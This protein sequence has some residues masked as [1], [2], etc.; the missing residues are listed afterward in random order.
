MGCSPSSSQESV[1]LQDASTGEG[2]GQ[3][4]DTVAEGASDRNEANGSESSI[5]DT[6]SSDGV[7]PEATREE[8]PES[9]PDNTT[10]KTPNILL[11]I[12]DDYGID[13]AGAYHDDNNDGKPDDGRT[14]ATTPRIDGI[15]KNGV[16]FL[17][18]WSTPLCSS[19]RASMLTGRYGFRTGIG[20]AIE[21]NAGIG[22][23]EP[24][25]PKI[26]DAHP[27]LGYVHANIGKWHLGKTADLNREQAPNTMGWSHYTGNLEG[28]LPQYDAWDK[29]TDGQSSSSTT[30]ATTENVDDTIRWLEKQQKGKPWLVWLAFN[31][32]HSPFHLPPKNLH[33]QQNLSGTQ[34][35]INQNTPPYYRAMIEAMDSEMG[36]LL[37]WLQT[38]NQLDNTVIVFLGDNGTPAKVVEAPY[39]RRRAK[40]TLYQGG[41]HVPF[42]VSGPVVKQ[43]GRTTDALIHTVDVF[44][45]ILEIAGVIPNSGWTQG[46]TYDSKSFLSVLRDP[47]AASPRSWVFSEFFDST[48]KNHTV[49]NQRYK[50]LRLDNQGT[51]VESMYDLQQDPRE[52]TDLLANGVNGLTSEQKAQYDGLVKELDALLKSP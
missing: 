26:L 35:D 27:G 2:G 24:S 46:V 8:A 15:C 20:G 28:S 11:I 1:S 12:A 42:C 37:A 18:A 10:T 14:Y 43:P 25:I 29:I 6:A 36:R 40:G 19:T 5:V 21:R 22:V 47:N 3:R 45:T 13:V 23:N 51:A 33:Q 30:Y 39:D 7:G 44:A 4:D 16:R 38:N 32:P 31:A 17:K 52:E 9:T 41:I 50:L 49:R 48:G 34:N